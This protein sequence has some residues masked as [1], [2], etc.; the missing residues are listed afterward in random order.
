MT[1]D[2]QALTLKGDVDTQKLADAQVTNV[3][4]PENNNKAEEED[5]TLVPL[6]EMTNQE[7]QLQE[8][9]EK[10]DIY[11]STFEYKGEDSDLDSKTET[12]SE[13]HS[14]PLLD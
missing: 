7:L 5:K 10:Y 11:T 14:Y 2:L 12:E 9:E 4:E 3:E 1:Q 6:Y 8:E 13:G